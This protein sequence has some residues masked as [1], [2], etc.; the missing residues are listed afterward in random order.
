MAQHI[1]ATVNGALGRLDAEFDEN[2]SRK[3]LTTLIANLLS[4]PRTSMLVV[5]GAL[6]YVDRMN[7]DLILDLDTFVYDRVF[8]GAFLLSRKVCLS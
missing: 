4:K 5:L 6:T 3:K 1:F 8:I 2:Y 7:L